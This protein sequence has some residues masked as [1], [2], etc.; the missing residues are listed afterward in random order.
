MQYLFETWKHT[1]DD[2]PNEFYMELNKERNQ[3]R[4]LEVFA[5]G[6]FAYATTDY[7]YNT[8]LAK[9]AYPSID[10]INST[11]EF[12]AKLITQKEFHVKWKII[13]SKLKYM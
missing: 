3:E 13:K 4:V 12:S 1:F 5:D 2:E 10:E 6:E 9:Y 8:C 11:E 7:E